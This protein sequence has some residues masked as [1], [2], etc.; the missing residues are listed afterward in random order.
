MTNGRIDSSEPVITTVYSAGCW[1]PWLS[2][3]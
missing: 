2:S 3:V 1:V